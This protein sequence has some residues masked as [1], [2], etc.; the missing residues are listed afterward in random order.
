MYVVISRYMMK[1]MLFMDEKY[2]HKSSSNGRENCVCVCGEPKYVCEYYLC[3]TFYVVFVFF[4]YQSVVAS[5]M[6]CCTITKKKFS[7]WQK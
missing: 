6:N 3:E 1:N 2:S 5:A 7:Q 4:R